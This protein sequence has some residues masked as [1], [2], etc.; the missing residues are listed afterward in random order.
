[1]A[2]L[3][4]PYHPGHGVSRVQVE[5]PDLRGRHVDVV[6]AG[7][8][9]VIGRAQEAEAVRERL[10]HTFREDVAALLGAHAE[11]LED[12]LLL[13]HAGCTGDLELFGDL[14]QGG[15]AHLLHSRERDRWGGGA[16][17]PLWGCRG[18]PRGG[19][20]FGGIWGGRRGGGG[21][22]GSYAA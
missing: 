16:P 8:V 17:L 18:G 3:W 20:R 21:G 1:L 15:D 5:L 2:V 9:V 4:R 12:Q 14:R 19:G 6:R 13:A 11:D 10:E 7:Q 22:S